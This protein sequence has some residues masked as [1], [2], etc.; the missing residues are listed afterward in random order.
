MERPDIIVS[1]WKPSVKKG[2][3]HWDYLHLA[4]FKGQ[5]LACLHF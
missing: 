3:K 1:N 4:F 5:C 2:L